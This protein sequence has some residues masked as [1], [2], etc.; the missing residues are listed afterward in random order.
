MVNNK[1]IRRSQN[2]LDH[3]FNTKENVMKFGNNE[4]FEH[5]LAKFLLCWEFHSSGQTFI[6]EAIFKNKKRADIFC[7]SDGIAYEIL[8]TESKQRFEQKR[9][10]YPTP[11]QGFDAESLIKINLK[12]YL[13]KELMKE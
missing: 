1:I 6:C 9:N 7:L 10:T 12:K 11:V 2:L 4:T 8:H 3:S 5:A 13:K